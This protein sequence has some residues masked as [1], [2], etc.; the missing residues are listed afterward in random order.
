[1]D[2]R[3]GSADKWTLG[4][5][6][7]KRFAP[8][9]VTRNLVRRQAREALRQHLRQTQAHAGA[10]AP[11]TPRSATW[12]IRVRAPVAPADTYRSASSTALKRAVAQDLRA[13]LAAAK[14]A[15]RGA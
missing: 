13:L 3:P 7:A 2:D 11:D 4:V 15:T 6:V 1:V 5:V 9:A 12:V 14:P 8:K 10:D